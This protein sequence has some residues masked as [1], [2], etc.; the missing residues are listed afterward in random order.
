[1][2]QKSKSPTQASATH[3]YCRLNSKQKI[4]FSVLSHYNFWKHEENRR[5]PSTI[6]IL[7]LEE[8][9]RDTRIMSQSIKNRAE[10]CKR[11]V[12]EGSIESHVTTTCT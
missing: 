2:F 5:D 11:F 6:Y 1:M 3:C 8:F 10:V 9:V 12:P 4:G 7:Q